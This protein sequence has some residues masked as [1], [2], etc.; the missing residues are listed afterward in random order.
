M[1]VYMKH[2]GSFYFS[3]VVCFIVLFN[4]KCSTTNKNTAKSEKKRANFS[5]S[6]PHKHPSFKR[7]KSQKQEEMMDCSGRTDCW[8]IKMWNEEA[9]PSEWNKNGPTTLLRMLKTMIKSVRVYMVPRCDF[10]PV[11]VI[12]VGSATGMSETGMRRFFRPASC[13][14]KQASVW[15]PI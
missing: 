14:Q 13:K 2:A 5:V 8:W 3:F 4:V 1:N 12:R 10:R 6:S 11:R 9:L 15:R 7:N